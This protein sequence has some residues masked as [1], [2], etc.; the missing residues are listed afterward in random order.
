MAQSQ[1]TSLKQAIE[2]PGG[3]IL[4]QEGWTKKMMDGTVRRPFGRLLNP[5]GQPA[6]YHLYQAL[7]DAA[8]ETEID[9]P[10]SLDWKQI[11]SRISKI[12]LGSLLFAAL[13]GFA[14]ASWEGLGYVCAAIFSLTVYFRLIQRSSI[15]NPGYKSQ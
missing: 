14:V 13:V 4:M 11:G 7:T 1:I 10:D 8:K 2:S 12:A 5:T 15:D 3:S 6:E 9:W